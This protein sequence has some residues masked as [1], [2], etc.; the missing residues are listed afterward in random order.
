MFS[1]KLQNIKVFTLRLI[2]SL[3]IRDNLL[4]LYEIYYFVAVASLMI[5]QIFTIFS[6]NV[7]GSILG[8]GNTAVNINT[9]NLVIL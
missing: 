6:F 7:L 1:H 4:N 3:G 5:K 2:H 9:Q 8:I